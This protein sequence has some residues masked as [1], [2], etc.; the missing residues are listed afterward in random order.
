MTEAKTDTKADKI[1]VEVAYAL[2]D[3]QAILPL[4]VDPGT[5]AMEAAVKSG[6][7]GPFPDLV[8]EGAKLG[9]FGKAVKPDHPLQAGDRVEI[10]RPL[11]VDPKEVRKKRAAEARQRR[12]DEKPEAD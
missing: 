11:I 7:T 3:K 2:P 10:Y 1:P 4:E 5:T 6:I 12:A 9:I 8:L